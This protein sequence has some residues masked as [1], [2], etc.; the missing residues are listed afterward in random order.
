MGG[1]VKISPARSFVIVP[2][3]L[4]FSFFLLDPDEE[5]KGNTY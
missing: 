4:Q 3:Q 5:N 2:S 1:R